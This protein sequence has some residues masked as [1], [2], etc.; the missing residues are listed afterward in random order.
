M[1]AVMDDELN[2]QI[3]NVKEFDGYTDIVRKGDAGIC[4]VVRYMFTY[5]ILSDLNRCGYEGRW[6]F[7]SYEKALAALDAWSGADGT[8]PTGWHRHP[9]TGRRRDPD[10]RE[11]VEW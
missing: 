2:W 6:C 8:E 9:D 11:Y 10:G 7:S 4:C 1:S 3:A 5:A